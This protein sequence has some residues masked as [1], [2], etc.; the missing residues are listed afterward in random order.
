MKIRSD[1][2]AGKWSRE[3]GSVISANHNESMRV[4]SNVKAGGQNMNH[5]GSMRVKTHL[6]AG[7][8]SEVKDSHDRYANLDATANHNQSMKVRTNVKAGAGKYI[9]ET[10]KNTAR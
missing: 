2:R 4:R 9:G 8:R 10:E 5:N 1:I 6:K 3:N 7:K